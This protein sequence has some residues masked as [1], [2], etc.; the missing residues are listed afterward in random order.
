MK[1]NIVYKPVLENSSPFTPKKKSA[2]DSLYGDF[3]ETGST[4]TIV[5]D[6]ALQPQR[7]TR[8][9]F[10]E[11][12]IKARKQLKVEAIPFV[13]P[14]GNMERIV[15]DEAF[16]NTVSPRLTREDFSQQAI[17]KAHDA[18]GIAPKEKLGSQYPGYWKIG[19]EIT[20]AGSQEEKKMDVL[21]GVPDQSNTASLETKRLT[22]SNFPG[23]GSAEMP[24]LV[25][26]KTENVAPKKKSFSKR[27]IPNFVSKYF[28]Q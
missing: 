4:E 7:L 22:R 11:E 15:A 9:D 2:N 16:A 14:E 10:T 23:T 18:R 1:E 28:S 20:V 6:E 21:P 12:A 5:A 26:K 3:T 8:E 17:E 19:S 27:L 13:V 24:E 25:F